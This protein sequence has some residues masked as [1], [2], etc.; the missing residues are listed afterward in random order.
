MG[1]THAPTS[2]KRLA[3][4]RQCRTVRP[5][6]ANCGARVAYWGG[7]LRSQ[8]MRAWAEISHGIPCIYTTT[9]TASFFVLIFAQS[10]LI[11]FFLR[12]GIFFLRESVLFRVLLFLQIAVVQ[13]NDRP[14]VE[15]TRATPGWLQTGKAFRLEFLSSTC[16]SCSSLRLW[17]SSMDSAARPGGFFSSF[18]RLLESLDPSAR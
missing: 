15:N 18:W 7:L 1:S 8:K 3:F 16:L 2:A 9:T 11:G 10:V 17:P 5:C 12:L 6:L 4:V 13:L 14:S